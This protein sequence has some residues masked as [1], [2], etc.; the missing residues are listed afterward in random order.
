[1]ESRYRAKDIGLSIGKGGHVLDHIRHEGVVD[2][3]NPSGGGGDLAEEL[4]HGVAQLHGGFEGGLEMGREFVR[5]VQVRRRG[6]EFMESDTGV[7][8]V[9]LGVETEFDLAEMAVAGDQWH[10]YHFHLSLFGGD[11]TLA[12]A[13]ILGD[14][15]REVQK[16]FHKEVEERKS[17]MYMYRARILFAENSYVSV[18]TAESTTLLVQ[19]PQE[20]GEEDYDDLEAD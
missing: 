1:M 19:P 5:G 12:L 13:W 10:C 6:G 3:D 20:N 18:P 8:E 15:Q 17:S 2:Y 16:D 7:L 4:R 9:G 11:H 14:I